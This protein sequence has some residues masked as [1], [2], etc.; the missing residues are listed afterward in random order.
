MNIPAFDDFLDELNRRTMADSWCLACAEDVQKRA[1]A[2]NTILQTLPPEQQEELEMYVSA[3][4]EAEHSAVFVAY[5]IGREHQ[6][7]GKPF[8]LS[9]K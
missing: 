4:E 5:K 9:D 8:M 2:Y 7:M 1:A 6:M 3:C